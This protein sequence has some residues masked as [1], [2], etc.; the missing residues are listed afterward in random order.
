MVIDSR[1]LGQTPQTQLSS[2]LKVSIGMPVYNG[3][4]DIRSALNSLLEQTFSD[5]ELIIS[6]NASNDRTEAICREYAGR[7]SRIRYVRQSKNLGATENFLFVLDEAI[8]EYFMWA[9]ADDLR[10]PDYLEKNIEFLLQKDGYIASTSKTHFDD[11]EYN[12][13]SMGDFAIE[14]EVVP[15]RMINFFRGWHANARFYGLYRH[16]VLKNYKERQKSY[17]GS[18]WAWVIHALTYGKIARLDDGWVRLG[19]GGVSN[20]SNVFM[21][22]NSSL[23]KFV[24]PFFDLSVFTIKIIRSYGAIYL[25]RLL[26]RLALINYRAFILNVKWNL[27]GFTNRI[28]DVSL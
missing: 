24:L 22:H 10:S 25:I 23:V 12:S 21:R 11:R 14:D 26:P 3:E 4:A 6:D 28:D 9:A 1:T 8:G 16:S 18:D 7:D 5:F 2:M 20:R 17:F 19:S 13:I 15:E 27:L